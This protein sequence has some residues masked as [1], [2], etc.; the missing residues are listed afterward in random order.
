MAVLSKSWVSSSKNGEWPESRESN[1]CKGVA[2]PWTVCAVWTDGW[3]WGATAWND[4][5]SF[6]S[7]SQSLRNGCNYQ[8]SPIKSSQYNCNTSI[9]MPLSSVNKFQQE[10][11]FNRIKIWFAQFKAATGDTRHSFVLSTLAF[12]GLSEPQ[13][14]FQHIWD[15]MEIL[16]AAPQHLA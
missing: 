8:W 14:P 13:L 12:M 10:K 1:S 7:I 6:T 15:C 3:K 2:M 5:Q 4:T 11:D 16:E 9:F